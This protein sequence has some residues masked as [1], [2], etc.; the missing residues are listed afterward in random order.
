MSLLCAVGTRRFHSFGVSCLNR[1][2][3]LWEIFGDWVLDFVFDVVNLEPSFFVVFRVFGVTMMPLLRVDGGM[4]LLVLLNAK[5]SL[6][7]VG[8]G[9]TDLVK[10]GY[11]LSLIGIFLFWALTK[12]L[13]I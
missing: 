10:L 8:R 12:G 3:F 2:S 11:V 9:A 6:G 5:M 13:Y 4:Y 7:S 1:S